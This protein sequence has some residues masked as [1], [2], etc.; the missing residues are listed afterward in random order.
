MPEKTVLREQQCGDPHLQEIICYLENGELQ[1]RKVLLGHSDFTILDGI[2]YRV[3]KDRTLR[4]VLPKDDRHRLYLEVHNG[5]FSGHLRQVEVH[6]QLSRHYWWPGM[7]KDIDTWCR[8]C[9]KCATKNVRKTT[10][11]P[12]NTNRPTISTPTGCQAGRLHP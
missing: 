10:D 5:V 7:R 6:R 1:A 4:V 11:P 9:L 3:E 8:A 12:M 2:I